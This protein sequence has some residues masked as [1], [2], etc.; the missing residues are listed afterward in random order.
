MGIAEEMLHL[1]KRYLS[2]FFPLLLKEK[3]HRGFLQGDHS[4]LSVREDW[5]KSKIQPNWKQATSIC[6]S[7]PSLLGASSSL[8]CREAEETLKLL[9]SKLSTLP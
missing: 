3:K 6:N 4:C 9:H 2:F 5:Q 7:N 8:Q 1:D